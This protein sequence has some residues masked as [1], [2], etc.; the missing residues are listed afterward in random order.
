MD[1]FNIDI[2]YI[3]ELAE[4]INRDKSLIDNLY[5]DELEALLKNNI[6]LFEKSS[7]DFYEYT[8]KVKKLLSDI[9]NDLFDL[10]RFIMAEVIP[11][12]EDM[13]LSIKKHFNVEF[14]EEMDKLLEEINK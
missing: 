2:V 11:E 5:E 7:I 14:H 9:Y 8:N 1:I 6:D 3:K 10:Y 12:Y 4:I 13:S